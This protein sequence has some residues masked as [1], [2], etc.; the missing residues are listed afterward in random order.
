MLILFPLF[1]RNLFPDGFPEITIPIPEAEIICTVA[2]L[3]SNNSSGYDGISNKI[4][5]LCGEYLGRPLVF[6]IDP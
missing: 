2:S 1:L 6:T 4:L 5:K 3:K